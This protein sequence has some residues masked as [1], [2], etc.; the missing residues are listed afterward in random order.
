M[1]PDESVRTSF[2]L[3]DASRLEGDQDP[4]RVRALAVHVLT[5]GEAA[6]HTLLPVEQVFESI[7]ELALDPPCRPTKGGGPPMG[8]LAR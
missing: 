3:P 1:F 7:R 2:P 5:S 6:G 4:R 8:Y